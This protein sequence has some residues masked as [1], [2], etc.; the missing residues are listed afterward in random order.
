M[1]CLVYNLSG[2][3]MCEESE[4]EAKV[5]KCSFLVAGCASCVHVDFEGEDVEEADM[6]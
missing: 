4:E 5:F 1:G 3:P 2:N 6:V